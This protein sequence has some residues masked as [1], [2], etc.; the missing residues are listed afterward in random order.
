M[1]EKTLL[2]IIVEACEKTT[3][4][5]IIFEDYHKFSGFLDVLHNLGCISLTF[6]G[7]NAI[8][9]LLNDVI[10]DYVIPIQTKKKKECIIPQEKLDF[11]LKKI[12]HMDKDT[13]DVIKNEIGDHAYKN[14]LIKLK[15]KG[16]I[17]QSDR[18]PYRAVWDNYDQLYYLQFRSKWFRT[19]AKLKHSEWETIK[20]RLGTHEAL[21]MLYKKSRGGKK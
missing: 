9:K 8:I 10:P 17:E 1:D 6:K 21:V 11:V 13:M 2:N 5:R 14:A 4:N 7:R 12:L 15:E 19:F 18:R 3:D 16:I 20:S